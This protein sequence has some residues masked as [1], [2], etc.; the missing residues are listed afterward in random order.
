[1]NDQGNKRSAARTKIAVPVIL[2]NGVGI[3][4]DISKSGIYMKT[5]QPYNP[6]D[7]VKF[8]LELQYAVP[9]GPKLFTYA[10]RI[11][12]VEMLGDNEYGVAST[13]DELITLH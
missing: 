8:T 11:V 6:G 4:Q 3:S 1:M 13:I 2:E 5:A 9:E 7:R 12:R 10:G